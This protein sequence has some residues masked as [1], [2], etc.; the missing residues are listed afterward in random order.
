MS[1]DRIAISGVRIDGCHG[2]LPEERTYRQPFVVDI[3]CHVDAREAGASDNVGDTIS[4]ADLAQDA[5]EIIE[6]ESVNLIETLA[7]RIAEKVLA[8]GALSTTVTVHKPE[9]PVG[10]PFADASITITRTSPLLEAGTI[11]RVILALGS[12]LGNRDANIR[13]AIDE[14][15][16]LDAHVS[17]VSNLVETEA[18]LL[19]GQGPQ[20]AYL[21][22][23]ISLT[24][25]L[26]PLELLTQLQRIEV[27]GGRVRH[28][29]WGARTIDIDIVEIEGIT[30]TNP[31]LILPHPRADQR[32][33]VLEPWHEIEKTA[34][35]NGQPLASLIARLQ[36]AN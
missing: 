24:T 28:E 10:I 25:A 3:S 16:A 11:R 34:T 23:V 12:N 15:A 30:S 4:Y 27:R 21:N 29:R 9:A 1:S 20:P 22:A 8:R 35:L 14:I 2:V 18:M 36:G 7:E 13:A 32:L 19:P 6:G 17:A 31:R 33:F 5:R 26:A